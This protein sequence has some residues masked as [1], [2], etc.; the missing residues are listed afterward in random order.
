MMAVAV[1]LALALAVSLLARAT[2]LDRDRA[3]YP[4]WMMVIAVL[5]SLF[6]VM[7]GSTHA[8]LLEALAG[9]VFLIVTIIGFKRSLWLVVGALAAH[10]LLDVVH[11][12]LIP[13]PGVPTFWPA[14][15]SAY[16]VMAA[17]FLAWLLKTGRVPAAPRAV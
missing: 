4:A 17:A 14:F 5:Y 12:R 15:C 3:L 16:D 7:G 1:G 9:S 8:L 13:D 10:G 2:G 11:A 6:A